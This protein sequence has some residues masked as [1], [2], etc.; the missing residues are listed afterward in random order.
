MRRGGDPQKVNAEVRSVA[1]GAQKSIQKKNSMRRRF[2]LY[3]FIAFIFSLLGSSSM[4]STGEEDEAAEAEDGAEDEAA[5][6]EA[7]SG[8]RSRFAGTDVEYATAVLPH[9]MA[10]RSFI[11]YEVATKKPK[12]N[13]KSK[14]QEVKVDRMAHKKHRQF[15]KDLVKLCGGPPNSKKRQTTRM[16]GSV[17]EQVKTKHGFSKGDKADYVEHTGLRL[18]AYC[19]ALSKTLRRKPMPDWMRKLMSDEPDSDDDDDD[20]DDAAKHDVKA[21]AMVRADV[22]E[23]ISRGSVADSPAKKNEVVTVATEANKRLTEKQFRKRSTLTAGTEN[24]AWGTGNFRTGGPTALNMLCRRKRNK[25]AKTWLRH[26][27]R[28]FLVVQKVPSLTLQ[29]VRSSRYCPRKQQEEVE[30]EEKTFGKVL[31][32]LRVTS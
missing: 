11:K 23:A 6:D 15:G 2:L 9:A 31:P 25:W 29:T 8:G 14:Q 22:A 28:Y 32:R 30:Q 24:C 27:W 17:F 20:D 19:Q 5:E 7:A 3:A 16:L 13:K 10:K 18:H 4:A 1:I 26:S 21:V 12:G